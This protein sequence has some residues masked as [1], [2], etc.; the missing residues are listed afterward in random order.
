MS[1]KNVLQKN[2]KIEKKT[3]ALESIFIKVVDLRHA[4][5][6]KKTPAQVFSCEFC[7]IF[8]NFVF[9]KK[10][11]PPVAASEDEQNKTKLLHIRFRLSNCYLWMIR[12]ESIILAAFENELVIIF[13]YDK[14]KVKMRQK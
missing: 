5:L 6:L 10:L 7:E 2:R 12:Y 1:C 8:E 11:L 9:E 4:T 14:P 3:P 13:F